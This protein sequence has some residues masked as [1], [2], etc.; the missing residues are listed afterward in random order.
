MDISLPI[1]TKPARIRN[2]PRGDDDNCMFSHDAVD[3][4]KELRIYKSA[5]DDPDDLMFS[6]SDVY[7]PVSFMGARAS[8]ARTWAIFSMFAEDSSF[9]KT[10]ELYDAMGVDYSN[11]MPLWIIPKHKVSFDDVKAAM[12]NH[13]CYEGTAI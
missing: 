7:D 13:Y 10:Y 11:R 5:E 6:F 3:L 12:A 9:E 4:A 1:L 2:F 8:E